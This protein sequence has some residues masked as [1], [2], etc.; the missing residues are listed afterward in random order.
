MAA[1]L[2]VNYLTYVPPNEGLKRSIAT[3]SHQVEI[4]EL[5]LRSQTLRHTCS[6]S[7]VLTE[8]QSVALVPEYPKTWGFLSK[9]RYLDFTKGILSFQ[10]TISS[11]VYWSNSMTAS[12]CR[13]HKM[14]IKQCLVIIRVMLPTTR[15]VEMICPAKEANDLADTEKL[16][17]SMQ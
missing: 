9:K 6:K 7:R 13:A 10:N 17:Y 5:S 4:L 14:D 3:S 15:L 2:S 16:P 1:W 12:Q 11:L 8:L